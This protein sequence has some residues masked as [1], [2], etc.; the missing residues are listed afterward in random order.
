MLD[1]ACAIDVKITV[2]VAVTRD[3]KCMAPFSNT[4]SPIL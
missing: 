2:A 4:K 1:A 3:G